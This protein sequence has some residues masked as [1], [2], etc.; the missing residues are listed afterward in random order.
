LVGWNVGIREGLFVW[1]TKF[2]ASWQKQTNGT[3][4]LQGIIVGINCWN[5]TPFSQ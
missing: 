5:P 3:V 1:K 4:W 2:S